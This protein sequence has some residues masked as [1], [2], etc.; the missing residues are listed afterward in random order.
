METK[1]AEE[2]MLALHCQLKFRFGVAVGRHGLGGGLALLWT[3]KVDISILHYSSGHISAQ[4]QD[5][6]I[7]SMGYFTGF[8][9]SPEASSRFHSW[10]LL[11]RIALDMSHPWLVIEDFNKILLIEE[12]QGHHAHSFRQMEQFQL[13][14]EHLSLHEIKGNGPFYT[15]NNRRKGEA[16]TWSRLDRVFVNSRSME[17]KVVIS[18]QV[19]CTITSN[20]CVVAVKFS[21]TPMRLENSGIKPTRTKS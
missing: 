10:N 17:L 21:S 2:R 15:W 5:W 19:I 4:I 6:H 7:G 13:V 14:I 3:L 11:Q 9:G 20:H 8:Y 12:M 1:L 16:Q 18:V